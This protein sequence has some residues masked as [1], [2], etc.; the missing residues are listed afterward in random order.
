[1]MFRFPEAPARVTREGL[2]VGEGGESTRRGSWSR[3]Q[4]VQVQAV[5]AQTPVPRPQL[6]F[7]PL[8]AGEDVSVS[9]LRAIACDH[10]ILL[11]RRRRSK[12]SLSRYAL[13]QN[14]STPDLKMPSV[15]ST[16][17]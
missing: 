1:M 5:V 10:V 14:Q 15:P 11:F 6:L 13:Q 17:S 2:R 8:L 7:P 4:L 3:R 12:V 16:R 9:H